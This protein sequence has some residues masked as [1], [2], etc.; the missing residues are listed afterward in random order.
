LAASKLRPRRKARHNNRCN[1]WFTD[2]CKKA[3]QDMVDLVHE[4]GRDSNIARVSR[5]NY[6]QLLRTSK[7]E[8]EQ[9]ILAETVAKW[10]EQPKQ[11]WRS[12]KGQRLTCPITDVTAWTTYFSNLF[13][14]DNFQHSWE[15]GSPDLHLAHYSSLFPTPTPE[16]LA[17]ASVLNGDITVIEVLNALEHMQAHKAAGVDDIPAEM[18]KY[19]QKME[20]RAPHLLAPCLAHLF[21]QVLRGTY[22]LEWGQCAVAPVY[23]GKGSTT[24]MDSYRGIAVGTATSKLFSTII[25]HRLSAWAEREGFRAAGQA[26]FRPERGTPDNI[27]VLQHALERA[28]LQGERVHA[29]FIDFRKAYDSV[30]RDLLWAAIRG[31]GVH[32]AM[33]DTLQ[34]MHGNITMRLR[35][36]GM[37][38]DP[39]PA[40]MGVKQ[41]DPLSPLLFGL[42]IDR[43]QQFLTSQCPGIGVNITKDMLACVLLYADDLV[44]LAKDAPG[45]QAL[46]DALHIFCQAN[47][48]TVNTTKSVAVTFH[49]VCPKAKHASVQYAGMPLPVQDKF[50]YLG[51]PF[52]TST[53]NPIHDMRHG[54]YT[55][56]NAAM[57]ALLQRCREVGIH[58]VRLRYN[59]FR[60]LVATVLAYGCE[61]WSVYELA[62]IATQESAWG[63]GSKLLGENVHKTFLRDTLQVPKSACIVLMMSEVGAAPMM[64]GWAKQMAGWWNRMV[65]RRDGDMVKEALRDS[66]DIA[67][68][69]ID[70]VHA[71][72]VQQCWASALRAFLGAVGADCSAL[73]PIPPSALEAM[74]KS[75]QQFAWA[76]STN[77]ID[78][79]IALRQVQASTG[80]KRATYRAWFCQEVPEQGAGWLRFLNT[81]KQ[82][83]TMAAFRLGTHE[84]GVNA[85]RFGPNKA[86]RKQRVCKCCDK[87][88]VDDERH[89][90]ECAEFA[91]LRAQ[92]PLL[93]SLPL[94]TDP[95]AT[96][97]TAMDMDADGK[98]WRALADYLI[99]HMTKRQQLLAAIVD[100]I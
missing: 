71:S 94:A 89:V 47:H 60:S 24:D 13:A 34:R 23:K 88:V 57:H 92:H 61:V 8:C 30:N 36:S 66:M 16:Q 27:F 79:G 14:A 73:S 43:C 87:N 22:P 19:A 35:L 32:G 12:Y 38:G 18:L 1:A 98:R 39:F 33:L 64:H 93:P 54:H 48:L 77:E 83:K 99:K 53:P 62:R 82:I 5:A 31:M 49:G 69:R 59:L 15:G 51:I 67:C 11:F 50:T 68:G 96:M 42:F 46:L 100:G 4:H 90:F 86:E 26:G 29:A 37:L 3:R 78:Q 9:R 40:D 58:N 70:G 20:A 21:N 25:T 65:A 10:Y 52:S 76:D 97:R 41:G 55:K 56:A 95:D 7:R 84:L 63:M 2:A 45:L 81:R 75:W 44:L 17:R 6:L 72:K 91:T 74:H 80:F 85:M 28:R